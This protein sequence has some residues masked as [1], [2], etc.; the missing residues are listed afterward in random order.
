MGFAETRLMQKDENCVY[1]IHGY[2]LIRNDQNQNQQTVRPPHGLALYVR[3][4]VIISKCKCCSSNK[5]ECV[6]LE[7]IHQLK[8]MQIVMIYNSP[9]HSLQNLTSMLLNEVVKHVV[10]KTP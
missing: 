10:R 6:V 9:G 7:T 4:D 3:D 1:T 2:Q 5:F 8:Q